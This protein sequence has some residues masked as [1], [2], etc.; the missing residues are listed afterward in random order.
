[1]KFQFEIRNP[2]YDIRIVSIA[3]N[4]KLEAIN[5]LEEMFPRN[6]G[7]SY[8]FIKDEDYK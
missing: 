3:A 1:M 8:N 6:A 2:N 7:Y 4:T 5:T